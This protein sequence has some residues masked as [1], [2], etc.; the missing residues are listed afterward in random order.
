MSLSWRRCCESL[1]KPWQKNVSTNKW[2]K[3]SNYPKS[4]YVCL[5]QSLASR[6]FKFMVTLNIIYSTANA[7][8]D[9]LNWKYHLTDLGLPLSQ[10][11]LLYLCVATLYFVSG[12]LKHAHHLYS[13]SW[14]TSGCVDLPA[15]HFLFHI[16]PSIVVWHHFTCTSRFLESSGP[17]MQMGYILQKMAVHYLFFLS[18]LNLFWI[19][20]SELARLLFFPALKCPAHI[21]LCR[22]ED[23]PIK[24]EGQKILSSLLQLGEAEEAITTTT[25]YNDACLMVGNIFSLPS[26]KEREREHFS[27]HKQSKL[28]CDYS[29]PLLCSAGY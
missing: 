16:H 7:R 11:M 21:Q 17:G 3:S 22:S 27:W 26:L 20:Y 6:M 12:L 24:L 13:C 19:R 14:G 9:F 29:E 10:V 28:I 23:G 15:K 5:R 4:S 1:W 25:G 18:F 8:L 2:I